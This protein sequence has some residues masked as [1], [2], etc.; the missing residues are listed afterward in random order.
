MTAPVLGDFEIG[1][2]TDID[3]NEITGGVYGDV[4]RAF[5]EDV[6]AGSTVN[7]YLDAVI[8]WD[9]S[10]GFL[11][12]SEALPNGDF[13]IWFVVPEAIN[14]PHYLWYKDTDTG[15]TKGPKQF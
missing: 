14:G 13:E 8:D 15:M 2:I 9:G 10:K 12:S 6:T 5:G 1:V 3:G 7:L 11:N 4:V